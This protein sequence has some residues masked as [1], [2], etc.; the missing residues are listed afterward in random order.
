MSYFPVQLF[1]KF[2]GQLEELALR[3]QQW[4]SEIQKRR[5]QDDRECEELVRGWIEEAEAREK[6][7]RS[8]RK[9]ARRKKR[10]FA[11]ERRALEKRE[12]ALVKGE[13]EYIDN[14]LAPAECESAHVMCTPALEKCEP[15]HEERVVSDCSLELR[16]RAEQQLLRQQ[17]AVWIRKKYKLDKREPVAMYY[18]LYK[19]SQQNHQ[20]DSIEWDEIQT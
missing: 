17:R 20:V 6:C 14:T 12:H 1:D 15:A 9:T 2:M 11:R 13:S 19:D 4:E 3:Q 8:A 7:E 10:E 18:R 16:E 5:D